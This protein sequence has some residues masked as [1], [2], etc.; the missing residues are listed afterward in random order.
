MLEPGR[1][2]TRLRSLNHEPAERASLEANGTMT[3]AS[4]MTHPAVLLCPG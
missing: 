1:R 3:A 2:S 4:A